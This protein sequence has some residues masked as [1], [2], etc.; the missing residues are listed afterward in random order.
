MTTLSQTYLA[1]LFSRAGGQGARPGPGLGRDLELTLGTAQ[2]HRLLQRRPVDVR[3]VQ[4][5]G[6]LSNRLSNCVGL[7]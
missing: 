6:D 7:F 5:V 4:P 2:V 1:G 3:P